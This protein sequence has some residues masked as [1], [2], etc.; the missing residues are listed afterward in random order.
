[1]YYLYDDAAVLFA[2]P[3][4]MTSRL[5]RN[6]C[7]PPPE[8]VSL[9]PPVPE[10]S[11]TLLCDQQNLLFALHSDFLSLVEHARCV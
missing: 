7:I 4:R 9:R 8:L 6:T 10:I 3:A 5:D 1:M 2:A 11:A